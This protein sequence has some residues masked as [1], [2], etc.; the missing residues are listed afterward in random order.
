MWAPR[1]L[2]M[3]A[4]LAG[5]LDMPAVMPFSAFE[6][7]GFTPLLEVDQGKVGLAECGDDAA[8]A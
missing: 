6:R 7:A 3:L 2:R 1:L 8:H 4:G 5:M